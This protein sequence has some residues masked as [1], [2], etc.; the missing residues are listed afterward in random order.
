MNL[1]FLLRSHNNKTPILNFRSAAEAVSYVQK[2]V[3]PLFSALFASDVFS[4][5]VVRV[6]KVV[7]FIVSLLAVVHSWQ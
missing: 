6:I 1:I 4:C 2:A 5:M 3:I 7:R